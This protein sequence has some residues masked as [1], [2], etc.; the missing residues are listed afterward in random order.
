M[1]GVG[2]PRDEHA[3]GV[4]DEVVSG[5][6]VDELAV[7]APVRGGD[8]HELAVARGRREACGLDEEAVSVRRKQCRRDE[9]PRIVAC[10]RRVD[11]RGDRRVVAR[12]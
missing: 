3:V 12:H 1:A 4:V 9:D 2:D 11:D 6:C 5:E 10:L 8:G 7:A